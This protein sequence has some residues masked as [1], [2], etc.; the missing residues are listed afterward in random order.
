MGLRSKTRLI[1]EDV[2]NDENNAEDEQKGGVDVL[3]QTASVVV[4]GGSFGVT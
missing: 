4:L 3:H 1:G 2:A